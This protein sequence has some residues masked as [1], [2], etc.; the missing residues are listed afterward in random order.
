MRGG[1][2]RCP[3]PVWAV[4][5]KRLLLFEGRRPQGQWEGWVVCSTVGL[6]PDALLGMQGA[7][8]LPGGPGPPLSPPTLPLPYSVPQLVSSW[9]SSQSRGD[10]QLGCLAMPTPSQGQ[11]CKSSS[12]HEADRSGVCNFLQAGKRR[13]RE[14]L[15]NTSISRVDATPLKLSC[16]YR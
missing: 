4:S 10:V 1:I 11:K 9:Y 6:I 13:H 12:L 14:G 16:V 5:G 8:C 3:P 2:F 7:G 15:E